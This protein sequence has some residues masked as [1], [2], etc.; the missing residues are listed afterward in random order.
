[1]SA[2]RSRVCIV[3]TGVAGLV[4]IRELVAAGHEVQAYEKTADVIGVWR[5][6]YDSVQLLTSRTA[7]SFKGYPMPETC[8]TF[9][10]G[11]DYRRYI[12]WLVRRRGRSPMSTLPLRS[13]VVR[14]TPLNGG[15]DGW[16]IGLAD[17]S[18]EHFD[19][20]VAAHGH[21]W[22]PYLPQVPGAFDGPQLHTSQHRNPGDM[23]GDVVLVVG[24][25]NSA[26]DSGDGRRRLRT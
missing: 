9:P 20:L 14:A 5:G 17:G 21:P 19:V 2:S 23:A 6:V 26:C 7:T 18:T 13:E 8:P 4:A 12:R 22:Q 1:M 10:S 11:D 15:K 24:S 25:G 16:D 3:G